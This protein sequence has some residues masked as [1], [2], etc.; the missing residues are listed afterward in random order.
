[1]KPLS[2]NARLLFLTVCM[3]LF[4]VAGDAQAAER[5]L[6]WDS[7]DVDA[8]LA[9]DGVLDVTERHAM[10]F[11]GDWNGGERVFNVRPR[12]KLEFISLERI[13]EST[14]RAEPLRQSIRPNTVDEYSWAGRQTL[15]WRSRLPSDPPFANTRLIYV[16][17][18]RLSG[19]LLKDD[20]Q[21]RLDHDFAFPNR[22]G[23]ILRFSLN[24]E[25]DPVWK[26]VGELQTHYNAG[27]LA[28]G[29]S[30]VLTIP[31]RNAGTVSP[32]AI[33]SSRSPVVLMVTAA[34]VMIFALIV[35]SFFVRE[36][37]LGRFAEIHTAMIDTAWIEEN[38]VAYPAE[39]L[40]A[41]WDGRVG[42]P[43]VVALIARMTA[44]GKLESEVDGKHSMTLRLKV[45]RHKLDGYERA[46]ID[47][48][49]FNDAIVTSTKEVQR[50]YKDRG[51]NPAAVIR[52]ELDKQVKRVL[53]PGNAPVGHLP[54][55][56]LFVSG[57]GLLISAAVSDPVYIAGMI[58]GTFALAIFAALLRIPGW[59]FR[60]RIR[61]GIQAAALLMIPALCI[62][63]AAAA[64]IWFVAGTGQFELPWAAIAGIAAW[65]LWLSNSSISGMKSRQSAGAIAFRK[66]LSAGRSFFMKELENPRPNL[67]DS[68]YPWLIAFGLGRQVDYWSS[69]NTSSA[70]TTDSLTSSATDISSSGASAGT[71]WSGGG[72]LSG[73]A[74]A[75]GMWAAA[76]AGMA[77]G[78]ATPDS[79]SDGGGSSSGGSSGGGGG[80]G[81]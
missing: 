13:E 4:W 67:R 66:R 23:A 68:W 2:S 40:G 75:T 22:A 26:P 54:G 72:G 21:Y 79:S 51:F 48:L 44:E 19:V 18:Y 33:D 55:I 78:V 71:G 38:I 64:F 42:A 31:L 69:R 77:A 32:V 20:S 11:T 24:L 70:A 16:L 46:L 34:I 57:L 58:G 37:S 35:L 81:W 47:G 62:S 9:A 27:P 52:P 59:L 10:I 36:R 74:G 12:Q 3:V 15:R 45:D 1:M 73:G 25:L 49:F 61:W 43:E 5:E 39:V 6:H 53:P 56:V 41:A 63:F 17:H 29:T 8:R 80:G 28:P 30:F 65:A 60:S 50:H 7:L 14:G 76:A